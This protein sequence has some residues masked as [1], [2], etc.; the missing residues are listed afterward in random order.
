MICVFWI[1]CYLIEEAWLFVFDAYF[2][3]DGGEDAL[4]LTKGEHTAQERIACIM[5]MTAFVHDAT[6]FIGEG[7]TVIHT[8]R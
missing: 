6:R 2:T 4:Y 8:H 5:A 7:H 1:F 3:V